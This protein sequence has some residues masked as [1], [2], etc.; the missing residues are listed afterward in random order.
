MQCSDLHMYV[1]MYVYTGNCIREIVD[2]GNLEKNY[3]DKLSGNQWCGSDG[4]IRTYQCSDLH[5]DVP[6]ISFALYIN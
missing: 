2:D 4:Y 5:S 1:R 3:F 6:R